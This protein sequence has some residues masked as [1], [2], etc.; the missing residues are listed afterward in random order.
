MHPLVRPSG[1]SFSL[2]FSLVLMLNLN[3]HSRA[4]GPSSSS[5][6]AHSRPSPALLLLLL[7]CVLLLLLLVVWEGLV[8][9][10]QPGVGGDGVGRDPEATVHLDIR[11]KRGGKRGRRLDQKER[12]ETG[13]RG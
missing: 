8:G 2:F 13:G 6:W 5:S 7:L 12:R 1:P 10:L 11:Q 3:L 4:M 9:D